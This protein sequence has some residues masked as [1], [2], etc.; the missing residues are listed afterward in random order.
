M[1][2]GAA[3]REAR[4]RGDRRCRGDRRPAPYA[5]APVPT[6]CRSLALPALLALAAGCAPSPA[7]DAPPERPNVVIILADDLGWADIGTQGARGF[8]TPHLDR[9][10]AEGLRFTDFYAAQPVC[11]ASRA[12]LLTGCYPNRIGIAGA[13]GPGARHGLAEGEV[14]LAELAR[15]QGYATAAFGK[16]HLGHLEPFLPT[17]HGFDAFAG[18]PYSNDM[19]PLHPDLAALPPDAEARQRAYP[20]LPFLE[21]ERIANP[22]VTAADQRRFTS[23][24]TERAVAFI[25]AHA[26]EP[27]LLYLA[28]PMP[29]VPLHASEGFAGRTARGLF[30]DVVEELD[31]SVGAVLDALARHGLQ[32]RTL[33]IFTSDNG[34]WL[35]YGDHAGSAGPLRE[36]KGTTFEGGVRVPCLMR[37]TGTIP[38]GRTCSEPLM[39]IDLLPTLA[40][41]LGAELPAHAIDGRDAGALLRGEPGARSPQEAYAFWY[42]GNELQALRSGR[43]KLHLPHGYR[44]LAGREPGAGGTPGAYDESARTG[45]ALYDLERDIGETSDVAELH[46]DVVARL[47]SLAQAMRHDLGDGL[48][49]VAATGAREP[50]RVAER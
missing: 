3:V 25:D 10:A 15:S 44:T 20:P 16:W 48:T 11:S 32:R 27:F 26:R 46:P 8:A 33:V 28:H 45:L 29:H 5:P 4:G 35:S 41:F 19:W 21:G 18:I 22:I 24:L 30:G 2:A 49:G 47:Q 23:D 14:T 31:A 34:P 50:G 42:D 12:A 36:G 6:A 17:R 39:T 38:A 13:L 1:R 9:L 40:R 37:W 43:W 7:A